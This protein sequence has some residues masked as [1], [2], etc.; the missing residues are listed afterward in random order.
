MKSPGQIAG[1]LQRLAGMDL[2][3]SLR[4]IFLRRFTLERHLAG[5][6]EA[7]HSVETA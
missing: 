1:A 7:I 6:A 5:L 4:D 3:E 2:A